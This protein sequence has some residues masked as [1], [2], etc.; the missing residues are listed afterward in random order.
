MEIGMVG[1]GKM[2]GNM[3]RRL[4]DAGHSVIGFDVDPEKVEDVSANLAGSAETLKDLTDKLSE[5]RT[6]WIMLPSG[7]ATDETVTELSKHLS[8]GDIVIDGGNTYY[9]D[10][11]RH[12]QE[13]SKR[14]I[15]FLDIGVSGGVW[16]LADGYCLM[17]GGDDEPLSHIKPILDTLAPEGAYAHVGPVGA[18][19]F[20]KMV[21]NGVEYAML[22]GYGEGFELLKASPFDLDL[23]QVA[24]VWMN[25]SVV[26]SWLLELV[27]HAF[28]RDPDMSQIEGCIEDSGEGR[29]TV[30]EAIDRA[31]PVPAIAAALFAR[32]MSRQD[33]SF[34]SKLIATLRHEFGGHEFLTATP[35][36]IRRADK[37]A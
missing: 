3:T 29:W 8:A 34:S 12:A 26:R 25:G 23:Q 28:R 36:E 19:H 1:L 20:T 22:E 2:G 35:E 18:G 24:S 4:R 14:G 15:R 5:T 7:K 21:H 30:A 31:V 11:Q 9:K 37:A 33:D 6:V 32:F 10:S 16:G 17:A 27:E 13:L